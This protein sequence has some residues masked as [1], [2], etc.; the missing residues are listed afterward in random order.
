MPTTSKNHDLAEQD[1]L[2]QIR[3]EEL[4]KEIQKGL[5][6]GPATPLDINEIKSKVRERLAKRRA[7]Q[8]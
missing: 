2:Y 6:S 1:R 3:L 8:Q 4:Q 7:N 5:D